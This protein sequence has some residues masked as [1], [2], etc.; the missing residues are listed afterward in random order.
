MS[1]FLMSSCEFLGPRTGP[2][3]VPIKHARI[4]GLRPAFPNGI[5][6]TETSR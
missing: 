4:G 2:F 3:F 6:F 1:S 5:G